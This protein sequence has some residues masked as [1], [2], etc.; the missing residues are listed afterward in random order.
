MEDLRAVMDAVGLERAYIGGIS[1]GGP[2]AMLFAAT[3]PERTEGLLLY[4]TFA[5]IM[6][7]E[8]NP[9]GLPADLVD[10]VNG[11]LVANW[12]TPDSLL[13]PI[14]MP[15]LADHEAFR[16]WL[17]RYERACASPG[18]VAE[19]LRFSRDI[20]VR[21]ALGSIQAPTLVVHRKQD[22]VV[23]P[24]LGRELAERIPDARLVELEGMDHVPWVAD[25]QSVL[26]EFEEFMTGRRGRTA[27]AP[28][29]VLATILFTDIVGSTERASAMGDA[30][31]RRLLDRHD[32]AVRDCL[33][34]ERGREVKTTGDGFLA[35]FDSPSSAV[36]SAAAIREAAGELGL[37]VRAG[38]HT[39]EVERRGDDVAGVAVHVGARV[40]ALAG[41]AEILVSGTVRDLVLGGS[42][43]FEDRGRHALKGVD[44]EWPL[45]AVV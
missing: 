6:W 22:L 28:E 34:R 31:W 10:Q 23:P 17:P 33:R 11:E 36:R 13:A 39:G 40:T 41:T 24:D 2:M 25:A 8:D 37:A 26:Q 18:A 27:R 7:S 14:W 9:H 42:F 1:E 15:S 45:L 38:L 20:D 44:G 32:A 35:T 21:A 43:S 5:C 4:G 16:R 30:A 29:R 19:I 12:G 3:Y